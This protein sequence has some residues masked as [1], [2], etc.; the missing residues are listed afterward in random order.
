M[1]FNNGKC[2]VIHFGKNNL[3]IKYTMKG[4]ELSVT[5]HERD[6]GLDVS[7]DL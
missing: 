5:Q 1:L 3:H 4:T 7:S 6:L 2:R